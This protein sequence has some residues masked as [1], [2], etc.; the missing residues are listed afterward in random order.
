MSC[1]LSSPDSYFHPSPHPLKNSLSTPL[2]RPAEI[3]HIQ[4]HPSHIHTFNLSTPLPCH[5]YWNKC[6]CNTIFN[7]FGNFV[8][9]HHQVAVRDGSLTTHNC[10]KLQSSWLVCDGL[11]Q[12]LCAFGS[13]IVFC[14]LLWMET[15]PHMMA[16]CL[17]SNIYGLSI[18]L[19]WTFGDLHTKWWVYFYMQHFL[20]NVRV[21]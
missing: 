3:L 17:R 7:Q 15:S 18:I 2:S 8:R 21:M 14:H 12:L 6:L 13:Q 5:L 1:P 20:I 10:T 9:S 11:N 19:N 4:N 16:E